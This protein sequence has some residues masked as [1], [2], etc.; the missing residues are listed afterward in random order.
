MRKSLY[1]SSVA[2]MLVAVPAYAAD[3]AYKAPPAPPPSW[4]GFYAGLNAGYGWGTS[5]TVNTAALPLVDNI[6]TDPFWGTPAGFTAAANSGS[7]SVSPSGFI[8]GAQVGYNWQWTPSI[9]AGIEVDLQGAGL[10]GSGSYAGAAVFGPDNSGL[11]DT[12]TGTGRVT[13]QVDWLGTVRARLGYLATPDVLLYATGGLAYGG[14]KASSFNTLALSDD[15]PYIYPTAAGIGEL[16][17]TRTGWTLGGGGEWRVAPGWSVKA[18][19]LYYNLGSANLVSSPV[20]ALDADGTAL[21]G[22]TAGATLVANAPVSRVTYDGIIVRAGVNY[23]FNAA[24]SAAAAPET[25]AP[26]GWTGFY[27][28]LNAGYAWGV[29]SSADTASI[30]VVDN[31]AGDAFWMTPAGFTAAANSGSASISQSGAIGGLQAGYNTQLSPTFVAGIEA[32][33]QGA[34]ITGSGSYAGLTRFGPD[35]SGL[36]STAAGAGTITAGIDWLGTLRARVGYLATP[37][38]L[39]YATGGLAFGGVTAR[40]A[41]TLSFTDDQPFVYPTFSGTGDSAQTRA[42]W[43]L[44]GGGEWALGSRWSVKAEALYYNLGSESFSASA[45]GAVDPDGTNLAGG[46]VAGTTLFANLPVTRVTYDGVI[47]R[48]GINYRFN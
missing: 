12:A 22:G 27:A 7:A 13:A 14:V 31:L 48:A 40:S 25:S 44:G 37:S 46:S 39:V 45:V 33:I 23:H 24:G 4:T 11:I 15:Q 38:V 35:A 2:G 19:A 5:G 34:G 43:T 32:D 3:L 41:H 30:P 17:Q 26:A 9:V 29:S 16:S 36:T 8:G 20:S 10:N 21:V 18:E 42:G 47:V 1:L 28:G 6:A